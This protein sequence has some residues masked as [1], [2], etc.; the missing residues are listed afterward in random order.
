MSK[1][2]YGLA[3]G[4]GG[5]AASLLGAFPFKTFLIIAGLTLAIVG[6]VVSVMAGKEL[7]DN[8]ESSNAAT[9]GLIVGILATTICA[10]LFF[11]CG[12]CGLCSQCAGN[13]LTNGLEELGSLFS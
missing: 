5:L 3:L 6:L 11:S 7:R 10:I 9:A 4:I 13:S 1:A 8:G 2:K 12:L